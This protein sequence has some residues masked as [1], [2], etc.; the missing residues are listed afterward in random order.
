MT[1]G[2]VAALLHRDWREPGKALPP[3]RR[4][5]RMRDHVADRQHLRVAREREVRQDLDAPGAID[6]DAG[7]LG[8]DAGERR[9]H[10]AGGPDH[11]AGRDRRRSPPAARSTTT[12]LGPDVDDRMLEAE[13]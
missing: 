12:L 9:G 5:W 1:R 6:V 2:R 4:A 10:D 8:E 3:T 13:R 7:S 11:G